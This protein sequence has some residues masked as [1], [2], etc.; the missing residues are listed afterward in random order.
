MTRLALFAIL[1]W[2]FGANSAG[3]PFRVFYCID[4][5]RQCVSAEHPIAMTRADIIRL[6]DIALSGSKGNFVGIID[7]EDATIQVYWEEEGI[8]R[9][10]M[11]VPSRRGSLT[12]TMSVVRAKALIA[13]MSTPLS[14]Y[15]AQLHLKFE[16]W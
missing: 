15:V 16:K 12:S 14:A 2:P 8:V 10:E 11:A 1:L 7:D 9:I 13:S 3:A 6:V 4:A 5:D